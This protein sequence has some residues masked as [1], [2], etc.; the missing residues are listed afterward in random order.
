MR[1]TLF[2]IVV[3]LCLFLSVLIVLI[4]SLP[5]IVTNN[6]FRTD[7]TTVDLNAPTDL[8][9]NFDDV[10]A[11]ITSCVQAGYDAALSRVSAIIADGGYDQE[12]S[13]QAATTTSAIHWLPTPH[14]WS[15]G[16]PA[17]QIWKQSS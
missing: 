12:L 6:V 1:N 4:V 9:G 2:K 15:R 10:S 3:F 5:S 11:T 13:M 14:H 16:A 8:V 7:P 17:R